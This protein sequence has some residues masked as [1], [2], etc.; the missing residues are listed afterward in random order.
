MTLRVSQHARKINNE[1]NS[2][3]FVPSMKLRTGTEPGRRTLR[4]RY[5][6]AAQGLF[7]I[8]AARELASQSR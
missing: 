5:F 6:F 3:P 7:T 8:T 4:W 1:I 2:D